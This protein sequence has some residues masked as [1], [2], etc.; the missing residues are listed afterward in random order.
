MKKRALSLVLIAIFASLTLLAGCTSAPASTS[1]S[2]A[3]TAA[4]TEAATEA[5]A[6]APEPTAT[7]EPTP[8]DPDTASAEEIEAGVTVE[9]N[10][11]DVLLVGLVYD[12][13][14]EADRAE[15]C[16]VVSYDRDAG[17]VKLASLVTDIWTAIE[18]FDEGHLD[19]A[20]ADGGIDLLLSTV[21]ADFGLN[22]DT[23]AVMN[24]DEFAACIDQLGGLTMDITAEE[25]EWIQMWPR[26]RRS[27]RVNRP[28]RMC[29]TAT[30]AAGTSTA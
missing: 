29:A 6:A 2:P 17:T 28:W 16:M 1:A 14:L 20:Y 12:E 23:Y 18:G 22:L 13:E 21:N 26:E 8:L 10:T 30:S 11:I 15:A 4:A 24:F 9:A 27:F 19:E 5:P 25:A 3:A 7:A